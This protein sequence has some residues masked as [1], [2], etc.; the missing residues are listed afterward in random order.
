MFLFQAA[1]TPFEWV[2]N[3]IH[4]VG[5]G[6][7]MSFVGWLWWKSIKFATAFSESRKASTNA[8]E[9]IN[10]MA[11]NHFPHMEENL[12]QLNDKTTEGNKSLHDIATGIAVLVDRGHQA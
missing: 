6:T 8:I 9:Q 7:V 3:H 12:K 11:T 2:N 4:M 10:D 1:P 5:W